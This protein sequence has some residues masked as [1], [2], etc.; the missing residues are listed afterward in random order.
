MI[1]RRNLAQMKRAGV[2]NRAM[3][4]RHLL[5]GAL[6]TAFIL[7]LLAITSRDDARAHVAT[8]ATSP[9]A[10]PTCLPPPANTVSWWPGD[11]NANDIQNG[12]NGALQNG[13]TFASGKV[14]SAFSFDGNDD[15]V[16]VPF[17][18][19]LD[20]TAA[21]SIDAWVNPSDISGDRGIL[22]KTVG[23]GVNTQYELFLQGGS[24]VFRLIKVPGVEHATLVSD[25]LVP[26]N[27]WTHIA[28]TWDGATMKLFVN[29]VQQSRM[30]P[31]AGTINGGV[32]PTFIGKEG[33]NINHFAGLI[34]EVEIFSRALSSQEVNAIYLA[35]SAGKCKPVPTPTP[36]PAPTCGST[37]NAVT[38]F[39]KTSNP[40]G[41]WSY[42]WEPSLGGAFTLNA[43]ERSPYPGI[44]TWEG[45]DPGSDFNFPFVTFN[46][47]GITLN[48]ASGISQP[49]IMLNLHPGLSGKFS[50]LR[51]TA[52]SS[53][54]F[55]VA[56]LFQGIDTRNTTSDVHVLEDSSTSLLSANINGFGDQSAF[57]FT[58]DLAAGETLDFVVG[59]GNGN[60]N[61]DSTGLA[62]TITL[63]GN[64]FNIADGDVVGLIAAIN[65]AN[66]SS[67]PTTINL[68]PN[69]H[70]VLTTVADSGLGESGAR[71]P[72]GL[73]YIRSQ[74]TINGGGATIQRSDTAGTPDFGILQVSSA[75]SGNHHAFNAKLSLNEV[76][77][78][79]ATLGAL[80][81]THGEASVKKST[82]TQNLG[83]GINDFCGKISVTN[84][85]IS[86]NTS[87]GGDG[88]GISLT[89]PCLRSDGND[90]A[91]AYISF[92]TIFE[93]QNTSGINAA[94]NPYGPGYAIADEFGDPG[95]VI[96]KNSILA[97]P[98]RAFFPA[99]ACDGA[100]PLSAGHNIVG[101]SSC[102]LTGPGDLQNT[103]P[104]LGPLANNGGPTPTHMP[105][106]N[107]PAIDGVPVADSTDANGV[108]IA[109]DQRGV[110]RPL[111]TGADIGAVEVGSSQ[112]VTIPS[113]AGPWS[114]DLN[115]GF[116]Y[117][118]Q[119]YTPPI[120]IDS[121]SGITLTPGSTVTVTYLNGLVQAGVGYA[122]NDGNGEPG[123]V[124]NYY[125]GVYSPFPAFFMNPGPDVLSMELVG[126]F[127][128]N[129]VIVGKPFPI[130]NGPTTLTVPAGANQLLL[131]IND[132]HFSDNTGFFNVAV[133]GS[134][135][136]M[137]VSVTA[138][139]DSSASADVNCQAAI[140]NYLAGTITSGGG[141]SV[142]LTQSPAAGTLVGLGSHTVNITAVGACGSGSDTVVFTVVD[143]TA[144]TITISTPSNG[145]AYLL[146]QSVSASYSCADCGGVA[147]CA[148]PVASGTNIN[149][150][151]AGMKTF[152]VSAS[153]NSG[154]SATQSVSYLITYGV[155]VLFDQTKAA[156]SGS[157]IPIKVHLIDASGNNVSSPAI[158]VHAMGVTQT[159]SSA[160]VILDD[161]GQANPDFDFRYDSSL[162]GYI[163][164]L[165][166]TGYGTGTY[167]LNYSVAGDPVNHAVQFQVRQ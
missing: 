20:L 154:N 143:N 56:G 107:S 62:V 111:G 14:G 105:L 83:G 81:I 19:N 108:P 24:V 146:N 150:A 33:S 78:T 76:T 99:R 118:G 112:T 114:T 134:S 59:W 157:T 18:S 121:S 155:R 123:N 3:Q 135:S 147:S 13:A 1:N 63:A 160:S 21:L 37:Y 49:P 122:P 167:L 67:C 93:N 90:P 30:F 57:N 138:P 126:T 158:V 125:N 28:A 156:K 165:K 73:P 127:A 86:Y 23:G 162:G 61:A 44:D 110:M 11:G 7:S 26:L 75:N 137:T 97:S 69:G 60:Y 43:G 25:V 4:R 54:S 40:N 5:I 82:I 161:A 84:S 68:A 29:A 142:T 101:D 6:L 164:N 52:P 104:L 163:F 70:Y 66:A 41:A 159:S 149:T 115:P 51:W 109:T 53:G 140:P 152:N 8:S 151:S 117:S 71:G 74:V 144:P 92:S 45:P 16:E 9:I 36:T 103:D 31:L 102:G 113:T 100:L 80:N 79:G 72:S 55:L 32:G 119:D 130:G 2:S 141:G 88:A 17:N 124:T 133:S 42:G 139:G 58:S 22:E 77:L 39:S 91:L 131:G 132:G 47:A 85:T 38:D 136:S 64:V 153:D 106:C 120:A 50:V 34:D 46:H 48:Y 129:G 166:T 145:T 65:S 35:D 15:S 128:N 87:G 10:E 116:D 96:I 12:N 98:T 94:G 89:S 27:T 148:G 95:D